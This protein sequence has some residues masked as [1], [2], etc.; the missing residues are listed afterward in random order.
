MRLEAGAPVMVD[1]LVP[2]NMGRNER[3]RLVG[4]CAE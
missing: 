1:M 2:E 3:V 4:S